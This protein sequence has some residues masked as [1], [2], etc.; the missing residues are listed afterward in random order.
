MFSW[1]NRK[2]ER[3]DVPV[4]LIHEP[5]KWDK[6]SDIAYATWRDS[7]EKKR[8]LNQLLDAYLVFSRRGETLDNAIDYSDAPMHRGFVLY[9]DKLGYSFETY[10]FLLE[11]FK[12][13]I[14]E[15]GY[16]LNLNDAMTRV[17]K[18]DISTVYRY[19]L[20]PSMRDMNHGL[21]S[22]RYGNVKLELHVLNDIP[23][24]FKCLSTIYRDRSYQEAAS[25][26]ELLDVMLLSA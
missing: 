17:D 13:R 8:I 26:R 2:T 21:R 24:H 5:L 25:F 11:L 15:D 10:R 22:Q 6:D 4:P 1:W 9:L 14:K 7:L 12:D 20:K 23:I 16:I 19:Y 18:G 3:D